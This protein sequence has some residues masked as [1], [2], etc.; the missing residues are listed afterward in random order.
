MNGIEV[1]EKYPMATEEVRAWFMEELLSSIKETTA[2]EDFKQY[3][4]D[5]GVENEKLAR[6][7]ELNPRMLFDVFDANGVIILIGID[8]NEKFSWTI[9][10]NSFNKNFG[11]RR[12]AE[13]ES[14]EPAFKALETLLSEPGPDDDAEEVVPE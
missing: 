9:Y 6:L 4:L 5:K 1:L 10:G 8:D 2:P 13:L 14:I 11:S 3:M 12:A 7:I